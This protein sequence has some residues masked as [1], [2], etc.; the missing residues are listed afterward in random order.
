MGFLPAYVGKHSEQMLL[1]IGTAEIYIQMHV[2]PREDESLSWATM[3]S[4]MD[5][6]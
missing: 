2:N 1:G 3:M 5:S 4:V 6:P